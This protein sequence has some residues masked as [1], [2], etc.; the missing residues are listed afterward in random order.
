M[1]PNT[2]EPELTALLIAPDRELAAE[3]TN[4]VNVSGAFQIISE[5]KTYPSPQTLE[6]RLRQVRPDVVL[7]DV[8][9]NREIAS[10]LIRIAARVGQPVQVVGLD[11]K[12]DSETL[13][14]SLRAGA[15][16][17]LYSPFETEVQREACGRLRRLRQPDSPL[18]MQPGSIAAFASAKPGSGASTLAT[19]TAF[20]LSR[21]FGNRVLLADLDLTN[22]MIGF[23]LKLSDPGKVVEALAQADELTP[24]AWSNF[25]AERGGIDVLGAPDVPHFEAAGLARLQALLGYARRH[26]DWVI[27][28]LPSLFRR[29]SLTGL[30]YAD[31]AFLVSTAE[32][33]SLHVARKA[34]HFLD[35]FGFP[36]ERCQMVVNRAQKKSEISTSEIEK[37]FNC[38]VH[39]KL[40]NDFA[41][42]NRAMNLGEPVDPKCE[43][44]KAID[45]LAAKL[46]GQGAVGKT[47]QME[48]RSV[49]AQV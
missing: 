22:G 30:S 46:S 23:F 20:A 42:V 15:S 11:R 36:K 41:A 19:Q 4:S 2:N 12:H 32:L 7:V 47:P 14:A 48:P 40:P 39:S 25:V 28:D 8:A 1:R 45:A 38:K 34:I 33:P 29:I 43:L 31:H 18:R 49:P 9:S 6:I 16:E 26:Y 5:L 37:L 10:E 3:F 21:N 27:L 24:G 44:G 17:F 35:R 13:L